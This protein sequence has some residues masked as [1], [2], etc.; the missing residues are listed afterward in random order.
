MRHELLCTRDAWADAALV[1][2]FLAAQLTLGRIALFLGAGVSAALGLPTWGTL[3]QRLYA[4][5]GR[6]LPDVPLDLAV[7][8]FLDRVCDNDRG[9][10]RNAVRDALYEGFQL[11]P[12]RAP[13][14]LTALAALTMG[15]Q[16]GRASQV[17]SY[18]F[19]D[20]L[21]AYLEWHGFL[22]VPIAGDRAWA[23]TAD[24]RV[25]HPHGLLP[26]D[27][28][29]REASADIVLDRTSFDAMATEAGARWR[30]TLG[31][32]ARSH[33]CIF[34]GLSGGDRGLTSMLAQA[35]RDHAAL[36]EG[37]PY[38]GVRFAMTDDGLNGVWANG[39][40]FTVSVD[41]HDAVAPYLM[42]ICQEAAK[43]RTDANGIV[44]SQRT[45][46]EN[47]HTALPA[48]S[49]PKRLDPPVDLTRPA[50]SSPA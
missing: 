27:P 22:V 17:V 8:L 20:L 30:Q 29:R 48:A 34:V 44:T 38:M 2:R 41:S 50:R 12:E 39:G 33:S 16:R 40:V 15:S 24:V 6:D 45:P 36:S 1:R 42:E 14:L 26:Y 9:R 35:W 31:G 25:Y 37:L 7:Q 13:A 4:S 28:A 19:D 11:R 49:Q 21:E 23:D 47:P 43:L 18:N 3:V 32:I 46:D 10:F 5:A